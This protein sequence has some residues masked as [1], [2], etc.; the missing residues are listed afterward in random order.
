MIYET[1]TGDATPSFSNM[2]NIVHIDEK[3][4][5]MTSKTGIIKRYQKKMAL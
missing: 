5:N 2:H 4:F 3:W 1:T